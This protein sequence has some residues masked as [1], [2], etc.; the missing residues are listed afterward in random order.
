LK[1]TQAVHSQLLPFTSFLP[2]PNFSEKNLQPLQLLQTLTSWSSNHHLSLDLKTKQQRQKKT[3]K[4]TVKQRRRKPKKYFKKNKNLCKNARHKTTAAATK[5][6]TRTRERDTHRE[7]RSQKRTKVM[8]E[9]SST[10]L[11]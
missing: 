2:S 9:K 4:Y 1:A 5:R 11:Q 10:T 8:R 3:H 6:K 7:R